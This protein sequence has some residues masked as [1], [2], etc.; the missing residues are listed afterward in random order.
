[1]PAI[2]CPCGRRLEAADHA[3][4]LRLAREHIDRDHAKWIGRMR[5][6]VSGSRSTPT[7]RRSS[8]RS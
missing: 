3:E 7:A 8:D 4:L 2:D 1:M 6:S 5:G